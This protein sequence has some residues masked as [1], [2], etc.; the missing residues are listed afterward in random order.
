MIVKELKK[1]LDEF[2]DDME[3]VVYHDI[4]RYWSVRGCYDTVLCLL[5]D[6]KEHKLKEY[7]DSRIHGMESKNT[8]EVII[9]S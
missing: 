7:V 4:G 1:R 8:E 3:I 2:P 6:E 9:I 5:K